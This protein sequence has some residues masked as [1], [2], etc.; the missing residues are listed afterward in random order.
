MMGGAAAYDMR[1][2]HEGQ[3]PGPLGSVPPA[4]HKGDGIKGQKHER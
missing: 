2:D 3:K 1:H 4:S